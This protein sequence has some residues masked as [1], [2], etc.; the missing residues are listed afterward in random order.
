MGKRP[1]RT[2]TI[3]LMM[4]LT[5]LLP[6]CR[7]T[8]VNS[9]LLG[10]LREILSNAP[11]DT[12]IVVI[13]HTSLQADLGELPPDASYDDKINYLQYIAELAQKDILAWLATTEAEDVQSFWLA[14]QIALSAPPHVIYALAERPDVEYVFA[15]F[16]VIV[17]RGTPPML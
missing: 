4:L 5:L 1:D 14:S 7:K 9:K 6:A 12:M 16:E 10:S 15:D 11:P 17:H 8:S 13:A 2:V 3:A